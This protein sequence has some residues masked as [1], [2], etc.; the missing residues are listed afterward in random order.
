MYFKKCLKA[1]VYNKLYVFYALLTGLSSLVI[2]LTVQFLVNN[3]A[4]SGIWAN[5][6]SFLIFVSILLG[7]SQI[8]RYSQIVIKES[9][10]R[11]IFRDELVLWQV[12][13]N[14][15]KAQYYFEIHNL[16]K[17]FSKTYAELIEM[18]LISLFGLLTLVVF[19]PAF[20]FVLVLFGV[21]GFY[22]YK[23]FSP[24]IRT[25]IQESNEKYH[26]YDRI[27]ENQGLSNEDT[28]KY[29]TRR[30]SHFHFIKNIA[31]AVGIVQMLSQVFVLVIGCLLIYNQQ[32]SVGQLVAAEIIISG[33]GQAIY[34]L[35]NS[36]ES[37]FDFE[38]SHYKLVK[39][40]SAGAE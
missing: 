35:P 26:L 21:S 15:K 25:S 2:P 6:V 16:L 31:L 28:L 30:D 19:H 10:L 12:N 11:Q 18:G 7:L 33:I 3:L 32:L 14:S 38:T 22:I 40:L 24:S 5:I 39:A 34:K 37:L 27:R 1:L 8:F 9:L 4:L 36:L 29:I 23:L 17:S 20:L 13:D